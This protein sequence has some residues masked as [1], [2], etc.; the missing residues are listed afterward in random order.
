[1]IVTF[2]ADG[3]FALVREFLA[4]RVDHCLDLTLVGSGTDDE[5]IGERGDL[6]EVEDADVRRFF[7]FGCANSY[8]PVR[9]FGQVVSPLSF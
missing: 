1:V 8:E 9:G 2:D 6:A 5:I 4:D 7:R 3:A